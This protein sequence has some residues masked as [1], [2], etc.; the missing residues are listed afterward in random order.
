MF[1]RASRSYA[2]IQT[3][4]N[5]PFGKKSASNSKPAKIALIG[6]HPSDRLHIPTLGA[7][8]AF[9]GIEMLNYVSTRHL[10]PIRQSQHPLSQYSH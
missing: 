6:M 3:N 4:P 5:P 2:T 10:Q 1:A 9:P 8:T 7:L